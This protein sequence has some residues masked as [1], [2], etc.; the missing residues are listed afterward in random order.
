MTKPEAEQGNIIWLYGAKGDDT[1]DGLS[2]DKPVKSIDK[3]LELAGEGGTIMLL[4]NVTIRDGNDLLIENVTLKRACDDSDYLL[5]FIDCE[6]ITFD[7]VVIDGNNKGGGFPFI[8]GSRC[9]SMTFPCT[10][11]TTDDNKWRDF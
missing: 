1:N 10:A 5:H 7:N 4:G 8:R 3:A 2:Q 9:T 6:N 11:Y